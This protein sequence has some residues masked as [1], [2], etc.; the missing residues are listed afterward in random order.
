MDQ[1]PVFLAGLSYDDY[2]K[3]L[4]STLVQA[5]RLSNQIPDTDEY[6]YYTASLTFPARMKDLGQRLLHKG[7]QIISH[8]ANTGSNLTDI[9]PVHDDLADRFTSDVVEALDL[10]LEQVV[11]SCLVEFL[12]CRITSWTEKTWT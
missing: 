8:T 7:Q 3:S 10:L 6:S 4:F 2:T 9:D 12:T 5:T 1:P 11:C